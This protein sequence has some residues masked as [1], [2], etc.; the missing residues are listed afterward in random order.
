ME[1]KMKILLIVV[2]LLLIVSG[3][4][5]SDFEDNLKQMLED[6]GKEYVRPLLTAF[7]TNLNTGLYNTAD[8][9]S[10]SLLRP[11]R[12]GFNIH[13]M[14]AMVPSSDKTFEAVIDDMTY[15]TATVFG[16]D[17]GHEALPGGFDVSMVPL[18]VP[19]FRFGLPAG[20]ELMVRY[21]P[22]IDLQD[23]GKVDFWGVAVK[24]S[25][26]QHIPLFPIDLAVQGAYQSLAVGDLIDL[27]SMAFNIHASKSILMWTLYGG[28]GYED[29]E[30][31][32]IYEYE[33]PLEGL[34]PQ[35]VKFDMKSDNN[36]RMTLGF[37]YTVLPFIH[38]NGDYTIS[39]YHTFNIGLGVTF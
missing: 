7:G 4:F 23:Y 14:M 10:P 6:N 11:V 39:E 38:L 34:D 27:T 18:F 28:L 29:V 1:D 15:E 16:K 5:A 33:P 30:L 21:L 37:R 12:F 2:S 32:A 17:G 9:L 36:Y 24:H 3:L 25:I 13:V 26:D 31:E 20:N 22:P 8:V 19:Q 35:E